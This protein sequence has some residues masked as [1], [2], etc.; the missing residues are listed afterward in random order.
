MDTPLSMSIPQ[1][2]PS[3][4]LMSAANPLAIASN[5]KYRAHRRFQPYHKKILKLHRINVYV[6]MIEIFLLLAPTIYTI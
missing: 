5:L 1:N 6:I 2:F 3:L 4:P